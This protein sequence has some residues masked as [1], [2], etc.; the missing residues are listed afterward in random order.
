MI[1]Q[2]IRKRQ[3]ERTNMGAALGVSFNIRFMRDNFRGFKLQ[4]L[5]ALPCWNCHGVSF[6]QAGQTVGPQVLT[7]SGSE[8]LQCQDGANGSPGSLPTVSAFSS[9]LRT[10]DTTPTSNSAEVFKMTPQA[11]SPNSWMVSQGSLE[12][13][14]C[15]TD[16]LLQPK[17]F[18]KWYML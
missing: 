5:C 8:S 14:R 3:C 7:A 9:H 17:R 15:Q 12:T 18:M 6:K 1:I 10:C 4:Y 2:H 11:G 13:V 16:L